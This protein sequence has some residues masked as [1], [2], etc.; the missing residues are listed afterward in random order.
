MENYALEDQLYRLHEINA[1]LTSALEEISK[2][3]EQDNDNLE[4]CQMQWRGCVALARHTLESTKRKD[5]CDVA[6]DSNKL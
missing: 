4:V 2:W 6:L 3:N 1:K 5:N